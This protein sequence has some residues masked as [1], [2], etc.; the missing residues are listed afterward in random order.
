[1]GAVPSG[2]T[3]FFNSWI[4]LSNKGNLARWSY[5]VDRINAMEPRLMELA[6]YDLKK[7]SLSLR[8]RA[9]SG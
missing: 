9:R 6:D 4:P 2:I 5:S 8:Y 7:E 3:R 1:V